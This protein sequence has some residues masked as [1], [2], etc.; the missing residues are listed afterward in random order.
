MMKIEMKIRRKKE[1]ETRK[2]E[3]SNK[4]SIKNY[5]RKKLDF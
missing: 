2:R 5:N 3:K 4:R 1:I